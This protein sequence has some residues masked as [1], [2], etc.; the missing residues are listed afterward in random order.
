MSLRRAGAPQDVSRSRL[1]GQDLW[2]HP[3]IS[4]AA[5]QVNRDIRPYP[6][7]RNDGPRRVRYRSPVLAG[8]TARLAVAAAL[9]AVLWLAVAWSLQ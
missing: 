3:P 9:A 6:T 5:P 1:G 7:P 4:G 2:A 8:V